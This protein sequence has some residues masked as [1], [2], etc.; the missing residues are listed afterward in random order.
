MEAVNE[1]TD[2]NA[3]D[4]CGGVEDQNAEGGLEFGGAQDVAREDG[5]VDARDVEADGLDGVGELV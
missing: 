1:P 3:A 5:D 2:A 4:D